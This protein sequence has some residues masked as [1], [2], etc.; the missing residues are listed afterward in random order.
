VHENEKLR[1]GRTI[2]V[3]EGRGDKRQWLRGAFNYEIL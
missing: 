3:L 2:P 1:P